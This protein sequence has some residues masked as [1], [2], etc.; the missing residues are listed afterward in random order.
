MPA[1]CNS[2]ERCEGA[3]ATVVEMLEA[4]ASVARVAFKHG[5]TRTRCFSGVPCIAT[6]S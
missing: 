3:S 2:A 1:T 6:A 4:V 5:V